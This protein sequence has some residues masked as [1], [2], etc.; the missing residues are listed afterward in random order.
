MRVKNSALK[1]SHEGENWHAS[2]PAISGLSGLNCS[3][4]AFAVYASQPRLPVDAQP[5][6]TRFQ[7]LARLDWAGLLTRRDTPKG[8]CLL[9]CGLPPFPGLAWRNRTVPFPFGAFGRRPLGLTR[10]GRRPRHGRTGV[11][12]SEVS[13]FPH[14]ITLRTMRSARGQGRAPVQGVRRPAGA[15]KTETGQRA[16]PARAA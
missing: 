16:H 4:Y 9:S 2:A 15:E 3:A 1:W 13:R 8:F 14:G 6:K 7:L 12:W 5:R 11:Q 10:G